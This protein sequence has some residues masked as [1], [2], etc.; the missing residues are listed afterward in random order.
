[1][2]RRRDRSGHASGEPA[3]HEIYTE[4]E[5]E[6]EK[7]LFMGKISTPSL[8]DAQQGWH[9]RIKLGVAG[10]TIAFRLDTGA[11]ETVIPL[12]LYDTCLQGVPL[13]KTSQKLFAAGG[14]SLDVIGV[15]ETSLIHS[16]RATDL[17]KIYVID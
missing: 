3:V 10:P 17:S 13:K 2:C 7:M 4:E 8:G 14:Q 5:I 11:D 9:S 15:I 1:V 12:K 6:P 16:N